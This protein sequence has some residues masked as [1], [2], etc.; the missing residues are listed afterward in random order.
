MHLGNYEE[1]YKTEIDIRDTA[2]ILNDDVSLKVE[3]TESR[4]LSPQ[5]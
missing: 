5:M 2:E 1:K 4:A 3:Y